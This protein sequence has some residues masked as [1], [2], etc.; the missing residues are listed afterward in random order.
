MKTQ[1]LKPGASA[2]IV[3]LLTASTLYFIPISVLKYVFGLPA[4][5]VYAPGKKCNCA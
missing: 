1:I 3:R 2:A 4:F 5:I